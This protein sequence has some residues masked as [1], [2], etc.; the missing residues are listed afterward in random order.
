MKPEEIHHEPCPKMPYT[1]QAYAFDVDEIEQAIKNRIKY[2]EDIVEKDKEQFSTF[3][4]D[5]KEAESKIKECI[6]SLSDKMTDE[7]RDFIK[8]N[9]WGWLY[10]ARKK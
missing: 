6:A 10:E 7:M 9:I 2:L 8:S 3:D 4:R 1:E 5:F